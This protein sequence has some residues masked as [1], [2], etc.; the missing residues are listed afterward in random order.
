MK[1]MLRRDLQKQGFDPLLPRRTDRCWCSE[2]GAYFNSSGTLSRHRV[3]EDYA[4][5]RRCL[6]FGEMRAK[7][8]SQL[9]S[10][11]WVSEKS[12]AASIRRRVEAAIASKR[13]SP[14][15]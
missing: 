6:S 4:I 11:H 10:G 1:Y 3:K 7:G 14:Q 9:D 5:E 2:C 8:W 15:G 13:S 12:D